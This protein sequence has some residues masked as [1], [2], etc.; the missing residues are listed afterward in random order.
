L[1]AFV[2]GH[3]SSNFKFTT[4]MDSTLSDIF[5]TNHEQ[6]TIEFETI[7]LSVVSYALT[8]PERIEDQRMTAIFHTYIKCRDKCCKIIIN[9]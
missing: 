9:N 3:L 1:H 8:Q 5:R 4:I 2:K 7:R 6:N